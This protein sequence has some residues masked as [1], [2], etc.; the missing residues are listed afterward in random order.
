M[1]NFAAQ[2]LPTTDRLARKLWL[3][4]RIQGHRN[5]FGKPLP[6]YTIA[7]LDFV[8]EMAALDEPDRYSFVR[9]GKEMGRSETTTALASWTDTLKGALH[10]LYL[11]QIGITAANRAVAAY[12]ARKQSG[13]KPGFTRH[14]KPTK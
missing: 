3:A 2:G 10:A 5:P 6:E 9:N 1:R 13:L 8:L 4:A 7:Q 12:A 14:G 11:V